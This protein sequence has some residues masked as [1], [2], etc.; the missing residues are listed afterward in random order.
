MSSEKELPVFVKNRVREINQENDIPFE[1]VESTENPVD[2]ATRG[3][4]V[5]DLKNNTLWWHGAEWLGECED[6]WHHNSFKVCETDLVTI[7]VN[8]YQDE[9]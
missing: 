9:L 7:P 2:S 3:T 8:L 5:C 1:Y 4:N 6:K